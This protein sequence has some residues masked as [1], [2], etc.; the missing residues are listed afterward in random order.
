MVAVVFMVGN[1]FAGF[2]YSFYRE[3]GSAKQAVCVVIGSEGERGQ[4][5]AV[6]EVVAGEHVGVI[7]PRPLDEFVGEEFHVIEGAS[8]AS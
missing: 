3:E 8:S 6:D 5:L 1:G 7:E 2:Q 4:A